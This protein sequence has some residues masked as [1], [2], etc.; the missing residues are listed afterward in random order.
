MTAV[1]PKRFIGAERVAE[2][3]D[4]V[5][6]A[7]AVAP[8]Y[9]EAAADLCV[10]KHC[11]LNICEVVHEGNAVNQASHSYAG[12]SINFQAT[13]KEVYSSREDSQLWISSEAAL[14]KNVQLSVA[15]STAK[16]Y[17][18]W[19]NRFCSFCHKTGAAQMPFSGHTAAVFL[20][21]LAE[22]ASGLGGVDTARSALRHYFSVNCP[23]IMCPTD[24]TEVS[25]AMKGIKRR[26]AKPV[27]KKSPLTSEQFYKIL[28][29]L[30]DKGG[31]SSIKLCPLRLAAQISVMFF[32]FSRFE[33]SSSLLRSQVKKIQGDLLVT[34]KKRKKFQF[35]EA[36]KSVIAGQ[37]GP[38]N[39]VTVILS[40][41]DRLATVDKS[42]DGF[43]FPALRSTSAGDSVLA[44]PAS[45]D[46]VLRQFKEV[47][48]A[49]GVSADPSTFGLHSMRRGA[50]TAA[51]NN[52]AT[53][54]AVQ[55]QMRVAS[56]AT[57]RRY[58]SLSDVMLKSASAAIFKKV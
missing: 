5:A 11:L 56:G 16:T 39:P 49:A 8:G 53:D 23:D 3:C 27:S 4:P 24:G 22:T 42:V 30:L 44:R 1:R 35:G 36:R 21:S 48:T 58:A 6:A 45:Y 14:Q 9:S 51:I 50:V 43:L 34:F 25:Q 10:N 17:S 37:P 57:V 19:W 15:E 40:Y 41:M 13:A 33:E 12:H 54:H 31:L 2:K 28:D 38:K 20:S 26:F 32:S 47:V 18:Y 46:S 52:G 29:K 7:A 55:K